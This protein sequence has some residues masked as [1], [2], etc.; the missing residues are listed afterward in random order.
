MSEKKDWSGWVTASSTA[1]LVLVTMYY[2]YKSNILV[3]AARD[4]VVAVE[5]QTETLVKQVSIGR[6]QTDNLVQQLRIA[7]RQVELSKRQ[8]ELLLEP[9]VSINED[10]NIKV[11]SG[12]FTLTI[13]NYGIADVTDV[14]IY[15][16]TLAL[17]VPGKKSGQGFFTPL[18]FE[19]KAIK[20][21][22]LIR[23]G[24][25]VPL[26][27][28][29]S[30][31][32]GDFAEHPDYFSSGDSFFPVIEFMVRYSRKTDKR[33]FVKTTRY[34]LWFND[35]GK[36]IDQ[37]VMPQYLTIEDT[38]GI[39]QASSL[40]FPDKTQTQIQEENRRM[41]L[42]YFSKDSRQRT[43]P[44]AMVGRAQR[45]E[46]SENRLAAPTN[47]RVGQTVPDPRLIGIQ[48]VP[49]SQ[50][51]EITNSVL[52]TVDELESVI[53]LAESD[54]LNR[55]VAKLKSG[56]KKYKRYHEV[57]KWPSG[58]QQ[59]IAL[60]LGRVAVL[61]ESY[62]LS[63]VLDSTR[64]KNLIEAQEAASGAR[65]QLSFYRLKNDI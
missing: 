42:D 63:P 61:Y 22:K 37:I 60:K 47:L 39:I 26:K 9:N 44:P 58:I 20:R 21:V 50:F 65:S 32:S 15:A 64:N 52:D 3:N 36:G 4:Q 57:E 12:A 7:Q 34:P 25:S 48:V 41:L 27:V 46:H 11:K 2:A 28:D 53:S 24:E 45:P 19:D 31:L 33:A 43:I 51:V 5:K 8:M 10:E 30:Y 29:V 38:L 55:L 6:E 62:V 40:M 13:C 54:E 35:G 18:T 16:R 14:K 1:I 49:P 56:L 59:Q 23:G 17:G